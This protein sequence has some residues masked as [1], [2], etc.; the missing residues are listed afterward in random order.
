MLVA[1]DADPVGAVLAWSIVAGSSGI[2]PAKPAVPGRP[3]TGWV[4][5]EFS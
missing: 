2:F 4:E 3:P 1:S 5:H